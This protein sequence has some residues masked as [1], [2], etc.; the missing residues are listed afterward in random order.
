MLSRKYEKTTKGAGE[1]Y[2]NLSKAGKEKSKNKVINATKSF[3]KMK[4]KVKR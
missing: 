4:N 3:Q 1:R 2:Q